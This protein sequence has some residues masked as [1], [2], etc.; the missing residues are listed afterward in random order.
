[1]SNVVACYKW[2]LDEA[3]IKINPDLSVDMK[4][5]QGKIS[6]YD[7][8][9]LEA[10]VQAAG[11]L[12]GKAVSL[13]FGNAKTKQSLKVV[14]SRGLKEGCWVNAEEANT[15]D[16]VVTAKVLAAARAIISEDNTAKVGP[17]YM[18]ELNNIK[19]LPTMKAVDGYKDVLDIPRIYT[20]YPN[21][22]GDV[23]SQLFTVD[24][25]LYSMINK[26]SG[27]TWGRFWCVIF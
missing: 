2:V 12:G 18:K 20:S 9:A 11:I 21:M 23:F 13:T 8:N 27:D 16:G 4:K 1:M 24:D 15:A 10:A 14:L 17:A 5:A 26:M 3:D 6:D 25:W 22:A 7:K 19:L